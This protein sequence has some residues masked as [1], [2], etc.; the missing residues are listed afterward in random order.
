MHRSPPT[1]PTSGWLPPLCIQFIVFFRADLTCNSQ[2]P[3]SFVF[4]YLV[5]N[6]YGKRPLDR[7][8]LD[9]GEE[10]AHSPHIGTSC[11]RASCRLI[12]GWQ[13]QQL[14]WVRH[15]GRSKPFLRASPHILQAVVN[16]GKTQVPQWATMVGH[17][18]SHQ[19]IMWFSPEFPCNFSKL[20]FIFIKSTSEF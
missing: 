5:G 4:L 14:A 13:T 8:C 11:W 10:R 19:G 6:G 3:R 1:L 2:F 20:F 17:S 15:W 7:A 16:W 9:P 18:S 12:C